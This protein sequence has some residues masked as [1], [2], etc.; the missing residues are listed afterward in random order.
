MTHR[1]SHNSDIKLLACNPIDRYRKY[2]QHASRILAF[3]S[4]LLM[5]EVFEVDVLEVLRWYTLYL[6]ID[7]SETSN[8]IK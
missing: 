1:Y 6:M 5:L 2:V 4:L 8:R 7:R 3:E